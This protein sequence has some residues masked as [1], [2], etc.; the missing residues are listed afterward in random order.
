[1]I[2]Y[3]GVGIGVEVLEQIQSFLLEEEHKVIESTR[4]ETM[5][6]VYI[7]RCLLICT[8]YVRMIRYCCNDR[9]K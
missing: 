2:E 9:W 7:V 3:I 8:F 5:R 4:S 1:M 6:L